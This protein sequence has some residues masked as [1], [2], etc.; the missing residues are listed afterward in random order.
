MLF[1]NYVAMMQTS[2]SPVHGKSNVLENSGR[3]PKLSSCYHN[4][5]GIFSELGTINMFS[6]PVHPFPILHLMSSLLLQVHV[7]TH[8]SLCDFPSLGCTLPFLKLCMRCVG[9]PCIYKNNNNHKCK[10]KI[11]KTIEEI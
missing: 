5:C 9:T 7:S 1:E 2:I 3:V 6:H 4:S 11:C 8:V 10:N